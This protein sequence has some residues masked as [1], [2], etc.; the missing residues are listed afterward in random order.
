[1]T[2]MAPN[3]ARKRARKASLPEDVHT[4]ALGTET[5]GH[6][7]LPLSA[8]TV[9]GRDGDGGW[10]PIDIFPEDFNPL[11]LA[12]GLAVGEVVMGPAVRARM[13]NECGYIFPASDA[14]LA[15]H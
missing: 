14:Q 3:Q 8:I 15:I 13:I 4:D 7:P 5:W 11:S 10:E 9:S 12:M 1:M 6:Y 2:Q